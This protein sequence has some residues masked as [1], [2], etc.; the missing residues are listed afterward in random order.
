MEQVSCSLLN[1]RIFLRV[2]KLIELNIT[3]IIAKFIL[4]KVMNYLRSAVF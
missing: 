4:S 2:L 1:Q 3:I